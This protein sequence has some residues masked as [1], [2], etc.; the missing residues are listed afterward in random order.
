MEVML[1]PHV[2]VIDGTF[3]GEIEPADRAAWFAS[4]GSMIDHYADLAE[5]GGRDDLLRWHRAHLDGSATPRASA[6]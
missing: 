6:R 1:K 4:Y 5:R 2:D 3:R